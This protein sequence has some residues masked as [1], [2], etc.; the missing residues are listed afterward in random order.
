MAVV[1]GFDG[2]NIYSENQYNYPVVTKYTEL[3][4]DFIKHV[5]SVLSECFNNDFSVR[6]E[7]HSQDYLSMMVG[8]YT[9]FIRFKCT[10]RTKWFSVSLSPSKRKE[11]GIETRFTTCKPTIRHWKA[12]LR[13]VEDISTYSDIIKDAYLFGVSG[14]MTSQE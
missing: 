10:D 3:E 5:E 11:E 8:D 4:R 7:Q 9:D 1:I 6:I 2:K 13:T 14:Y 12:K